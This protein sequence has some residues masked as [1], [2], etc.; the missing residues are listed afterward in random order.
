MQVQPFGFG[1]LAICGNIAAFGMSVAE[2]EWRLLS[3][4]V[5]SLC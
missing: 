2:A 3:S 4:G 1:Y 5:G